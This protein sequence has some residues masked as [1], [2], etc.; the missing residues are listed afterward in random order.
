MSLDNDTLSVAVG[1][2]R[3]FYGVRE[4]TFRAFDLRNNVAT[5]KMTVTVLHT[6]HPPT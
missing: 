4:L 1:P 3:G 6:N 2:V 5:Q